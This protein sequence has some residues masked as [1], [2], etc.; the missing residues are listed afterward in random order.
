MKNRARYNAL[1]SVYPVVIRLGSLGLVPRLHR[2]VAE[3]VDAIPGGTLVEIG[4]GPATVTPH[5]LSRVGPE[6]TVIG[7][8][9]AD[10]M[11]ARARQKARRCRS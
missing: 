3:E 10:K 5:L 8:D 9:I 11:I 6:G 4:C 2:A 7:V 1:A